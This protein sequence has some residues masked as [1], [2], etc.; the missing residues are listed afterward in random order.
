VRLF[1]HA[2]QRAATHLVLAS[3]SA[4]TSA[5]K[6]ALMSMTLWSGPM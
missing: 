2:A 6:K 3:L 5:E 4:C 1:Q